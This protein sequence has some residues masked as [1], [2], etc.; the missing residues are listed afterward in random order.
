MESEERERPVSDSGEHR[1]MSTWEQEQERE[2]GRQEVSRLARAYLAQMLDQG[3]PVTR[4]TMREAA[5]V[6]NRAYNAGWN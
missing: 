5:K 3:A 1:A 6:A 2:Q 4:E